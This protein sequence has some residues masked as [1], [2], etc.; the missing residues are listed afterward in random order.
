M[1]FAYFAP[2]PMERHAE[3]I[4]RMATSS[5]VTARRLGETLDGAPLDL[6]EIGGAGQRTCWIIGRQHPG[7][8][9]AEWWM[10]GFLER[11]L[12]PADPLARALLEKARFFVVPNMNP[13]GSRRGHLRTNAAGVNLNRAWA[14]PSMEQSPEVFLVSAADGADWRRFLFSMSTATR[15][16]PTTSSPGPRESRPTPTRWRRSSRIFRRC[17]WRRTRISRP[18][19]AIRRRRPARPISASA[20]IIVAETY[21]CLAMTL[22]MPFKDAANA[23][24]PRDGWSPARCHQLGRSS[25]EALAAVIDEVR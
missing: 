19:T 17:S 24:D 9:M 22:E 16:S 2:Y 3:L 12:D 13:D 8:T 6:L 15:R 20:P 18:S 11:L 14:A 25:L 4:E 5:F 1:R 7:E 21:G 10:E 23:P